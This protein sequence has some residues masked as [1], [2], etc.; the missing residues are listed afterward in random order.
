M[1]V[2]HCIAPSLPE[3]PPV[4]M[5]VMFSNFRLSKPLARTSA[6]LLQSGVQH[7]VCVSGGSGG[8][9]FG[10]VTMIDEG[11]IETGLWK[12]QVRVT[13]R[14]QYPEVATAVPICFTVVETNATREGSPGETKAAGTIVLDPALIEA[15]KMKNPVSHTVT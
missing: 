12:D 10:R 7:V 6:S 15:C 3:R 1:P 4:E 11:A 13:M 14:T 8:M 9:M 2:A 5:E